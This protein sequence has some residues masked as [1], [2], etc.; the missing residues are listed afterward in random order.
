M[1]FSK[2]WLRAALTATENIPFVGWLQSNTRKGL[3]TGFLLG[4]F[5]LLLLG[6]LFG[7]LNRGP[8]GAVIGALSG[9]LCGG[10]LGG[11]FGAIWGTLSLPQE[12]AAR[13][14][15]ALDKDGGRYAPR[16]TV[17]GYVEIFADDTLKLK[18]GQIYFICRG[19]YAYDRMEEDQT[20][21]PE[22][23]RESRQY[24]VQQANVVPPGILRRG[25][26]QRYPFSFDIP[27]DALPSH[28]GY[29]CSVRWTLHVLLEAPD[30][31][32]IEVHRELI[33]E[34][35][36]P[37]LPPVPGGYQSLTPSQIC[38]LALIL[39]RVV[40][41]EG[42]I[43]TAR[44]H[45][46]PL[47]SFHAEEI[48]AVLLRVENT[49]LGDDHIVYVD[50]WDP[51]SGLFRGTRQAGGK[52]TTYVW[53]ED[54]LTLSGPVKLEIAESVT[55]PFSLR[56]PAQWRPTLSTKDGKVVWKV[57][58][59][60]S[61]PGH[62]DIRAFHEIIVHTGVSQLTEMLEPHASPPTQVSSSADLGTSSAK[63]NP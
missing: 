2:R 18:G 36:V 21:K 59:I 50:G 27:Y 60:L 16:E 7:G 42:E 44:A 47:E 31:A 24:L 49:P 55:Y 41:A 9:S 37:A 33:V 20:Q 34:A 3:L 57:G 43:V 26:S 51:N 30:I 35:P 29:I 13:V 52:G 45:I 15:I 53:L 12:G 39:P 6:G 54:E 8:S 58:L 63:K 56:I 23:V 4:A 5:L 10:A 22:F 14:S 61:R 62:A 46:T 1:G 19:F 32:P 40:Y 38:Q 11:L 17:S 48:R 25:T 28:H